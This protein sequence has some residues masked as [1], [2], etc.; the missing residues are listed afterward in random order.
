M[1]QWII[2]ICLLL[3][4]TTA[5]GESLPRAEL[6]TSMGTI[7]LEL[8]YNKAPHSVENFISYAKEG[9]YEGTVFHR[10]IKDFMVQGGGYGADLQKKPTH[11]SIINEAPNGLKNV[12]GS[13]AMARGMDPNSA[14]A[15]FFINVKDNPNL[16]HKDLSPAG[17]G[18]SVFGKVLQGMDVVDAIQAVETGAGGSFSK[19]V[20]ATPI[21]IE[22]ITLKNIPTNVGKAE[23]KKLPEKAPEAV[24]TESKA[25]V[26]KAEKTPEAPKAPEK[27][28]EAV[29]ATPKAAEPAKVEKTEAAKPTEHK[30]ETNVSAL[31][32]TPAVEVKEP[33]A[34]PKPSTPAKKPAQNA[35]DKPT[36]PDKP[37]P[38]PTN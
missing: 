6:K 22:K 25:E 19:D 18:Y 3:A 9:F 31:S 28:A 17:M 30:P 37:E 13:L 7:V 10:V 15:Q 20:P 27:A 8:D 24:K 35:T 32:K 38:P 4:A 11:P 2:S 34:T 12:R 21:I 26:A 16:D 36:S 33:T 14:T 5:Q 29:K 1:K 23:T